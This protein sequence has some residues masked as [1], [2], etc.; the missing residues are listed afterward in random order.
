MLKNL[1]QSA[2]LWFLSTFT[3]IKIDKTS[4]SCNALKTHIKKYN[5][6]ITVVKIFVGGGISSDIWSEI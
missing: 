1:H 3:S 2:D 4:S 5:K 6:G